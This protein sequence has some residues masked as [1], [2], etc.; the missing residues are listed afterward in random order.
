MCFGGARNF[1]RAVFVFGGHS[2]DTTREVEEGFVNLACAIDR[3]EI[4]PLHDA[5]KMRRTV[6]VGMTG[7]GCWKNWVRDFYASTKA[8]S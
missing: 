1:L 8:V 2:N 5:K 6:P 3:R 4:P 7:L